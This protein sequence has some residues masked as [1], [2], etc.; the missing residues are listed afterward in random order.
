MA[1][2]NY[3]GI[4]G[5]N[6][7]TSVGGG[8]KFYDTT[9]AASFTITPSG[10]G[11]A[12]LGDVV[13]S[14]I[15][16]GPVSGARNRIINGDCRVAQRGTSFSTN[17][18][19]NFGVDRFACNAST[20]AT[21]TYSQDTAAPSNFNN[22]LKAT[23]NTPY[24]SLSAADANYVLQCIE[25]YNFGDF[26]FGTSAAKTFTV[27]FYVR[28]SLTGTF[29]FGFQNSGSTRWYLTTYTISSANT[30]EYKTITIAGDTTGTWLNDNGIGIILFW[31]LGCGS[32][33]VTSSTNSWQ[34]GSGT[35]GLRT[36]GSVSFAANSGATWQVT[37]VQLEAGS[38]ATPFERRSIGQELALCQRYYYQVTTNSATGVGNAW[39]YPMR[40]RNYSASTTIVDGGSVHPVTMRTSPTM[41]YSYDINDGASTTTGLTIATLPSHWQ[42]NV[43]VP[44]GGNLD[45]NSI[46]LSAEL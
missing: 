23:V 46:F 29:S 5:I 45:F 1:I 4:S 9:G 6:S 26:G 31:D 12:S 2:I 3:D 32:N 19:R 16:S 18:T 37:G 39:A 43:S 13:V 15:N 14:S 27:S 40:L 36:S 34:A 22:S 41:T 38:T 35:A 24:S 42:I 28:S 33:Y 44:A 10:T 11:G 17:N 30:W 8:V 7:I 25:G 20:N 21:I